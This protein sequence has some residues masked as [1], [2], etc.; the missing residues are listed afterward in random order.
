Y[1]NFA[2]EYTDHLNNAR[3]YQEALNKLKIMK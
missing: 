3:I 2:V 1:H